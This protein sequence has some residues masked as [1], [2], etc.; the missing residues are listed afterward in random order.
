MAKQKIKF[1]PYGAVKMKYLPGGGCVPANK[2]EAAKAQK[3]L[4]GK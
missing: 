1:I 2:K 4:R 3:I